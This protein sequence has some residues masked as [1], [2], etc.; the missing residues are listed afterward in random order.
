MLELDGEDYSA[1]ESFDAESLTFNF[2]SGDEI[3]AAL[4]TVI[5]DTLIQ[6]VTVTCK[7]SDGVWKEA[8]SFDLSFESPCDK[9]ELT[10]IMA[11]EQTNPDSDDYSGSPV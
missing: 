6:T 8:A 10:T 11:T 9:P 4:N 3:N 1:I 7:D 2:L 5:D